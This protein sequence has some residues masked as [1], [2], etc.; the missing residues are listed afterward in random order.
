[1]H[2]ED[3]FQ[4]KKNAKPFSLNSLAFRASIKSGEDRTRTTAENAG[5][6]TVQGESGAK[7]GALGAKNA[8][9]DPDLQSIIERWSD[10]SEAVKDDLLAMVKAAC[11]FL[12]MHVF[13]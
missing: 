13:F 2:Q 9:I 3:I 4:R 10:L 12:K 11:A 1:M 8:T 5:I 7:Y 6:M